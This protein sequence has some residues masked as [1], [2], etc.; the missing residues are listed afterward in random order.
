MNQKARI[1]LL[2]LVIACC[3]LLMG[4][5]IVA[6]MIFTVVIIGKMDVEGLSAEKVEEMLVEQLA[7]HRSGIM[8]LA[9]V[10][11]ILVLFI[12]ARKA[13]TPFFTHT[14]LNLKTTKPIGV[15]SFLAGIAANVWF[16]LMVGLI[17]WPENWIAEYSAA[18]SALSAGSIWL[19]VFAI[20][21]WAP[22][23]EEILFRGM[24]YRYLSAALPAGAA[25]LFQ[26]LLFGGMHGTMIWIV[27]GS[28]MGC[29]LGYVRKRTGSLH[30]SVLMH[31]GFNGGA[32]LF[33]ELMKWC[34]DSGTAVV[35]TLVGSGALFLLMLYGIEYRMGDISE[36]K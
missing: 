29:I 12:W 14:G 24:I 25:L 34:G 1:K 4:S 36:I 6:D 15:L 7:Q 3:A 31:I 5:Q 22:V 23:I 30:A 32:Y 13:K 28:V 33:A 21:L 19:E 9:Y 8:L 2:L 16:G 11:T 20:V 10:L 17:P 18:S 27:Y 26:G 35:L